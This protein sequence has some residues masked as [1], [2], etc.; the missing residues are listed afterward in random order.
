MLIVCSTAMFL[1]MQSL[2]RRLRRAAKK[3]AGGA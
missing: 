3:A 2:Q 1:L